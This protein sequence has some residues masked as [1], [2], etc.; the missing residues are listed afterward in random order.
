MR[1]LPAAL[2]TLLLVSFSFASV[3]WDYQATSAINGDAILFSGKAVFAS[4]EGN[5]YAV[6]LGTG[7]L[8]WS[9]SAGEKILPTL[10]V[11]NET[12]IAFA[13]VGGAVVFL[14]GSG[15]KISSFDLDRKPFSVAGG[16]G[17]LY[18][19]SNDSVFAY[20]HAGKIQ[21]RAAQNASK[22]PLGYSQGRLYFTAGGKLYSLSPSSGAI[23]WAVA[24]EDSFMSVPVRLGDSV[25][26][27]ATD[28]RL[29]SF[30]YASGSR[31]WGYRTEGWVMSTPAQ[32]GS[33]IF[34]GSNDG[35]LYSLDPNGQ[36]IF[37]FRTEG[38]IWSTPVFY[39]NAG[40]T[41]AVF[42][43]NDGNLYGIDAGT[44]KEV[45]S[46]SAGGR[47]GTPVQ[48][49][50]AFVF[51]TSRGRVYSVAPSPICSFSWPL[52]GQRVGNWR[53]DVEGIAYA[54]SGVGRVDVRKAGDAWVSANGTESWHATIDFTNTPTGPVDV[55]CRATDASGASGS[56][57][58][59]TITLAKTESAPLLQM[60]AIAP[61]SIAANESF[62]ISVTD[63][64]GKSLRGLSFTIDRGQKKAG[65]SPFSLVLGKTAPVQILVEKDGYSPVLFTVV[66]T[67]GNNF[68]VGIAIVVL[69]VALSVA[70]L[71]F[72]RKLL[73]K[74]N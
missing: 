45:W 16:E 71:V 19:S 18:F 31:E 15:A 57:M 62:N 40:R 48:D 58:F 73:A 5:I 63:E 32:F 21:W 10:L 37:K 24:A 70:Y 23:N 64:R 28:G 52:Q 66:G 42:G 26:F 56:D 43:S 14:D 50:G 13:T 69:V 54:D 53:V 65:D 38:A 29:Y 59:S 22:G 60:F 33:A 6:E 1:V 3:Q 30:D 55:Q 11:A 46:F 9:Y 27:G 12:S 61:S 68:L 17:R 25:Y 72:G 44:G 35:H 49:G 74:K 47:L 67:G 39:T 36:L 8:A 20:N 41:L 2:F 7:S 51:G 34:F 4:Y